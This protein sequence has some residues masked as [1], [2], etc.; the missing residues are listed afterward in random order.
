MIRKYLPIV[1]L[2]FFG[3]L[4]GMVVFYKFF[5]PVKKI[6]V[7]QQSQAIQAAEKEIFFSERMNTILSSAT[8]TDFVK[9][10][11]ISRESVVFIRAL[12]SI[13]D[14]N[15]NNTYGAATGSGVLISSDGYIV[16]NNHVIA[17]G[18]DVEV[19]LNNNKE[20]QAE[21]IGTDESTDLALLKIEAEDLPFLAFGNSDSLAVGEWVM[22]V[23][24][25]FRLQSTV[26]AGI[27]SA[28]ARNIN[29]LE[30]FGVESFIQTDAAVNPGNSGGALVNTR[31][32]LVGINA[33]IMTKSGN[34]EGFSFAIPSN[35]TRKVVKDL[36]EFGAVQRGWLGVE[37]RNI[38]NQKAEELGLDDVSGVYL[39][40]I[41][42]GSGAESAGLR[43]GDVMIEVNGVKT[44]NTPTF[45]EQIARY[46]P[47]DKIVIKYIRDGKEYA[48]DVI[49]R[50]QLNTTD[51]VAIRKDRLLQDL[52]VEVRELDSA[53]KLKYG[54]GIYVVNVEVGSLI[55]NTN[56]E[57]GYYLTS[58][59]DIPVRSVDDFIDYLTKSSGTVVVKGFY[60]NYPGEYPYSFQVK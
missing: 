21:I 35:L 2:S 47:G 22:A 4:V 1:L 8:P 6:Y 46:R 5:N 42:K 57:P 33:A 31:G 44:D 11:N 60:D 17:S 56:L 48:S 20:Y 54:N 50:N 58:L 23:G 32:E 36:M 16:T 41:R 13:R 14:A 51:Y 24:N 28:K 19:L 26:T 40:V 18:T 34:Y 37:I 43:S 38:N 39:D 15:Y 49:L 53:E 3:S 27:V 30:N 45:M 52:G 9:A 59:N 25:P 55:Y 29:I 10:A 7:E 12:K